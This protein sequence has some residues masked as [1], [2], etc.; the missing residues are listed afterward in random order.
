MSFGSNPDNIDLILEDWTKI[1][2]T[3]EYVLL[4]VMVDNRLILNKQLQ[5]LWKQAKVTKSTA[6]KLNKMTTI[7][8]PAIVVPVSLNVLEWNRKAQCPLEL[9]ISSHWNLQIFKWF[10]STND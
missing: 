8:I 1:P 7:I 3:E 2:S 9:T 10:V 5:N 6:N 4:A